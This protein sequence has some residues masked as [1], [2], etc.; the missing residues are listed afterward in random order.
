VTTVAVIG[1]SGQLGHAFVAEAERIG[2]TVHGYDRREVD[3]LDELSIS[4]AMDDSS[5]THVV[6][7]AAFTDVVGC[8]QDPAGSS[9][10]NVTG[11]RL[12][13]RHAKRRRLPLVFISSDYVFDGES[14]PYDESRQTHPINEYGRQKLAAERI[15]GRANLVI[16]TCQV[17]G[18]D[19]RR[20]NYVLRVADAIRSGRTIEAPTDLLGTPTYAPDLARATLELLFAGVTGIR[21]VA[22]PTLISRFDLARRV[23]VAFGLP[24]TLVLTGS[25]PM[26][27]VKRPKRSGLVSLHPIPMRPLDDALANLASRAG[28]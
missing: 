24:E 27:G 3:L 23:A 28:S 10:I 9:A 2:V 21:H 22:G 19:S 11:T 13:S 4:S 18:P 14:G 5:A 15:V 20:K 7:A 1:A 8:E 17:F 12:V 16:R 25:V 26:D 6:L